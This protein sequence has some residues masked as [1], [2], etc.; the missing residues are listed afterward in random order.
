MGVIFQTATALN[1]H[2]E[3]A[4]LIAKRSQFSFGATRP[5]DRSGEIFVWIVGE[6]SRPENWSLF[7]YARDTTPRL[8]R[9]PGVVP[10][11]DVMTTAPETRLAV[12]SMLS[13]NPI[14]DWRSVQAQKSVVAAF[15]EAGFDTFWL[16]TQNVDA[17]AG[18]VPQIAT[19]AD[20]VRY[21]S[22]SFDGALLEEFRKILASPRAPDGNLFIVLHTKGSHFEYVRRYP[23]AFAHFAT[24]HA[25]RRDKI[26][27]AYDNS[28]LYT[29]WFLSELI[30]M[31]AKTGSDSALL[32]SSDHG[33]NLLDDSRQLLGH[34]RGTAHDLHTAVF[35]WLSDA[36]RDNHRELA[37]QLAHN[38]TLPLS[39]DNL[40]HSMLDLAGIRTSSYDPSFS[41]FNRAFIVHPRFYLMG[42]TIHA[43]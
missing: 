34:T 18:I 2:A 14:T 38:S 8:R 40:S 25:G 23:A 33:E 21:F 28:I 10:L 27:D 1:L 11:T 17:W 37:S 41:V 6:S 42:G 43:E 30:A 9:I 13:H 24:A 29:D 32:Y 15:D 19:E 4:G 39:L 35:F 16:S 3:N 31:L 5:S 20:T 26:V 22:Q 12:P 7:G 36:M